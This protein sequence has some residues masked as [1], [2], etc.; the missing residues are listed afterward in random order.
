MFSRLRK[1]GQYIPTLLL[2]FALA[3]TAW[4]SSVTETD[5]SEDRIYPNPV[6]IEVVGQDPGLLLTSDVPSQVSLTLNAPRSVWNRIINEQVPVRA[7]IDLSGLDAGTYKVPIQIQIEIQPVQIVSYTPSLLTLKLEALVSQTFDIRLIESGEVA[8]GFQAE[9]PVISE[10]DTTING[11]KSLVNKIQEV[12]A[13]I[14]LD[15]ANEDI[16]RSVILKALD[17]NGDMIEGVDIN[18]DSITVEI[19]ITQRGGYRNVVVKV[20]PIGQ[21]DSGY[22][23]TNISVFPPT[24]TVFS[25]DPKLVDDIPGYVDTAALDLNG[26]NDDLALNLPLDLPPGVSVVGKQT[27]AVQVGIA[28]IEGSL[29]LSDMVVEVINVSEYLEATVSPVT[30][31]VILSG[32]LPLLD[33]LDVQ[34][35]QVIV[36]LEGEGVGN[37]QRVPEV[38]ISIPDLR[39]ESIL[40]GSVEITLSV[41]G[42]SETTP[43]T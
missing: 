8:V 6:L 43:P 42:L 25:T 36:D 18:P 3:V 2:A 9:K 11:P 13:I 27:V 38:V 28:S 32:P 37:Y 23:V 34:H 26:A 20:V 12:Q 33:E 5:P 1:L 14:D 21:V 7:L 39:V 41:S 29:T 30:V 24:V 40:P 10:N 22:R 19:A 16:N 31:D 17:E 4:V 15:H 35:V